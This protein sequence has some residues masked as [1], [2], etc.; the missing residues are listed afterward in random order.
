M[1]RNKA[2]KKYKSIKSALVL[3]RFAWFFLCFVLP[4]FSLLPVCVQKWAANVARD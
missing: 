3:F 1:R 2:S 4:H